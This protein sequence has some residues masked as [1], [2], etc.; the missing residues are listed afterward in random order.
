MTTT[1]RKPGSLARELFAALATSGQQDIAALAETLHASRRQ[2]SDAAALLKRHQMVV[3]PKPGTYRLTKLGLQTSV[4]DLNLKSGP[5][6]TYSTTRAHKDTFRVRAWCSMRIRRTFTIGDII[7]DAARESEAN[8][9]NNAQRYL[10]A[11]CRAGIVRELSHRRPGTAPG[12]N[13]QKVF[14][15]VMNT[16]PLAPALRTTRG[17]VHDFNTGEDHPC[18]KT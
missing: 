14:R 15:L 3:S 9:R 13:G 17:V 16:G 6:G 2:I 12:S 10:G 4:E 18:Q 1:A 5:K 7:S 8:A 11:L